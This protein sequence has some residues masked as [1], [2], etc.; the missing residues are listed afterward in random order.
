M[1]N[2]SHSPA[3]LVRLLEWIQAMAS[4]GMYIFAGTPSHWRTRDGDCDPDPTFSEVWRRVHNVCLLCHLLET[5]VN[6]NSCHQQVSPWYVGRFAD[7]EEAN[8]FR[9][10]MREDIAFLKQEDE[11]YGIHRDYTPVV[12]GPWRYPIIAEEFVDQD[13]ALV[14]RF[15]MA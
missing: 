4:T 1:L 14:P 9:E 11:I 2:D 5:L 7:V 15:L 12:V 6:A 10:R 3:S 13:L 8:A